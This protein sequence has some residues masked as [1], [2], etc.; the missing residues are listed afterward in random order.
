VA[1]L[2]WTIQQQLENESKVA[3]RGLLPSDWIVREKH[4]DVGI[5]LEIEFVK[6]EEVENRLLLIQLKAI[7][8]ARTLNG[9]IPFRM[10]TKHLKYYEKAQLPV[11]IILWHK[12]ANAFYYLFAQR[13]IREELS[14]LDPE[15]RA[16]ETK[17]INF[18]MSMRIK[19]INVLHS[20]SLE[21][22]LYIIQEQLNLK[23]ER[24]SAFYWLDGIP[25]SDDEELKK[26]ILLAFSFL[27]KADFRKAISEFES[28]LTICTT[29]PKQKMVILLC[30]GNAYFSLGQLENAFNN[31]KKLIELVP[32][33]EERD[34]LIG[35]GYAIG[36]IGL[37][38]FIK[39]DFSNA[40]MCHEEALTLSSKLGDKRLRSIAL[41]NIA[42]ISKESGDFNTALGRLNEALTIDKAIGDKFGQATCLCNIGTIYEEK[43]EIDKALVCYEKGLKISQEV[44]FK[45]GEANALANIGLIFASK[46]DK[47]KG[48]TFY[49]RAL[50]IN[51]EIGD[52]EAQAENLSNMGL[53]REDFCSDEALK[54]FKRSLA[55]YKKIGD[56]GGQAS[57]LGNVGL[58]YFNKGYL[59][60]ALRFFTEALDID[61]RIGHKKGEA[62]DLSD[63]GLVYKALGDLDN[64]LIYYQESLSIDQ[65]IGH[66]KGEL[67]D[68]C[69]LGSI[70]LDKGDDVNSLRKL[71]DALMIVD[72]FGLEVDREAIQ[73][74]I[75]KIADKY[76]K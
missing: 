70:Y 10:E 38:Y 24:G 66:R 27:Q 23:P 37:I 49:E 63:I 30:L 64:A 46:G 13:Y 17:T 22:Y 31:L 43:G 36:N 29:S 16:K 62:T 7:R 59:D 69:T 1:S 56:L 14:T 76:C 2:K 20:L 60:K 4:P 12:Q 25:R 71:I 3:F 57:A 52:I 40:L 42:G 47:E 41:T 33:V 55:I 19:N 67:D 45:S 6:N 44:G 18:P 51:R 72:K 75:N 11:I 15:W 5:D 32:K 65:K 53:I 54:N 26:R 68:L 9:A 21:G 73:S 74:V 8:N 35:K 48:L 39:G 61:R 50:A 58:I 28:A 34:A